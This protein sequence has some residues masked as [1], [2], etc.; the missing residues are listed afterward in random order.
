MIIPETAISSCS[1]VTLVRLNDMTSNTETD[2]MY[3]MFLENEEFWSQRVIDEENKKMRMKNK[4]QMEA[5]DE[6]QRTIQSTIP[7]D[8]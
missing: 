7:P 1:S 5:K 2:Q 3:S 6:E 4:N 8:T